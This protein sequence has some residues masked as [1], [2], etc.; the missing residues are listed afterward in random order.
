[1]PIS[2]VWDF[3]TQHAIRAL[4][5]LCDSG[6]TEWEI[7][8]DGKKIKGDKIRDFVGQG[9]Y[10]HYQ[11]HV[12]STVYSNPVAF[13]MPSERTQEDWLSITWNPI[14]WVHVLPYRDQVG[15]FYSPVVDFAHEF[16][17]VWDWVTAPDK[18]RVMEH[19]K[20]PVTG[21]PWHETMAMRFQNQVARHLGQAEIIYHG[22]VNYN[23][24]FNYFMIRNG[25]YGY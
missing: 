24:I 4:N 19:A 8:I 10:A 3:E 7:T 12:T 13:A 14:R 6:V 9:R 20:H 17:Y 2:A 15:G 22:Q 5:L 1:M 23:P 16:G 18:V 11:V 21:D 25:I